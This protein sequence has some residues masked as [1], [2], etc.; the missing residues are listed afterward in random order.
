MKN[1]KHCP[2]AEEIILPVPTTVE[3]SNL[4]N[5]TRRMKPPA[6][7][8]GSHWSNTKVGA[9]SVYQGP[10]GLVVT[11]NA[12]GLPE[13]TAVFDRLS[14]DPEL[15]D[16]RLELGWMIANMLR[17]ETIRV[18]QSIPGPVEAMKEADFYRR[19]EKRWR[20][21]A[22]NGVSHNTK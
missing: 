18:L 10:E 20:N 7:N 9:Y 15:N 13:R 22:L 8:A 19:E 5:T 14:N 11:W 17:V 3:V 16:Q 2:T 1:T 6:L 12:L 4:R 21:W